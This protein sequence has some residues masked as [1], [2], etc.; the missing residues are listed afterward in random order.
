MTRLA[1]ALR[2]LFDSHGTSR[3]DPRRHPVILVSIL[4][5]LCGLAAALTARQARGS[6]PALPYDILDL[7]LTF[8]GKIYAALLALSAPCGT[9][10]VTSLV[11]SDVLFALSYACLLS[12]IYLWAERYLRKP[13]V[14]DDPAFTPT[15]FASA[16]IVLPFIAAAADIFLENIPLWIAAHSSGGVQNA[17][18]I[19][20]SVGAAAKWTL[21]GVF[22]LG[23]VGM[24]FS[25]PRGLVFWRLRFS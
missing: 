11:E 21:L 12:G 24:I 22:T 25:G 18:A 16:M 7:E 2:K 6:C 4:G 3:Y 17:F 13:R 14:G 19:V 10:I 9:G 23:L 5:A 15:G 20:G 8:S 1:T